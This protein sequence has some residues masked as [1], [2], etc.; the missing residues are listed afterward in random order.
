MK[1]YLTGGLLAALLA[2]TALAGQ[3]P[4]LPSTSQYNE[5]SQIVSTLNQYGQLVA[6]TLPNMVYGL[7][8]PVTTSGTSANVVAT[9]VPPLNW[10]AGKAYRIRGWGV[11]SADANAKTVT[12]ALGALTKDF[13]ATGSGLTWQFDTII[14]NVGTVASPSQN[15]GQWGLVSTTATAVSNTNSTQAL[16]GVLSLT[17]SLT[18]AT[19]GTM[20]LNGL[21][22]EVLN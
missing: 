13:T 4:L 2:S 9:F 3:W 18:A 1:R 7:T 21:I 14:Q 5:P 10:T 19:A 11:N 12:V 22:V 20:T 17:V 16:T 15:L 8:A 6:P